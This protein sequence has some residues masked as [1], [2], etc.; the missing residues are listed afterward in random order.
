MLMA[1]GWV[2]EKGNLN[3]AR[4][5]KT[6]AHGSSTGIIAAFDHTLS[7]MFPDTHVFVTYLQEY[8]DGM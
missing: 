8:R 7:S 6:V 3:P 1:T 5:P 2:D 4:V